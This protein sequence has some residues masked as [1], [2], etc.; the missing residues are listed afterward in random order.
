MINILQKEGQDLS[1]TFF[2]YS[3]DIANFIL[4]IL[5]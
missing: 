3:I 1:L 2:L 4:H 5:L